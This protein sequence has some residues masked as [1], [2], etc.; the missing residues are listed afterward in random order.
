MYRYDISVSA[1]IH[2]N[3]CKDTRKKLSKRL[4]QV[5]N[6]EEM[7]KDSTPPIGYRTKIYGD[8]RQEKRNSKIAEMGI[9]FLLKRENC[10]MM[11]YRAGKNCVS[12]L[13]N[14]FLRFFGKMAKKN[15]D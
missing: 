2:W 15:F 9:P 1:S 12:C 14:Y 10:K 6:A 5:K 4:K 8:G 3:F 13:S 11:G 7:L